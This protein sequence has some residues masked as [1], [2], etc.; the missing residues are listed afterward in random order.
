MRSVVVWRHDDFEADDD[1][2]EKDAAA[3]S[4]ENASAATSEADEI[5]P[6]AA[7]ASGRAETSRAAKGMVARFQTQTIKRY[8]TQQIK[9]NDFF[10][11]TCGQIGV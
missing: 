9:V 1:N 8:L 2:D 6:S 5:D 4:D 10:K 3:T 7:E 11:L